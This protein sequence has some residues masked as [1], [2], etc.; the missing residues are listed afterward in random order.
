MAWHRLCDLSD[1]GAGAGREFVVEGRVVAVFNDGQQLFAVDGMCAHQGGPIAQGSLNGKCV[2]CPWHGWQYDISDGRNLLT[3][4]H[5]LD[6][7]PIEIRDE[8]VW[9]ELP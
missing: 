6:C 7:F 8:Q 3:G 1:L 4:K 5:M 9:L 2:T